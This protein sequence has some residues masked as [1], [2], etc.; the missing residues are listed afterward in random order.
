MTSL[1]IMAAA[2]AGIWCPCAMALSQAEFR[3]QITLQFAPHAVAL[4]A[5]E[6]MRIDVH[7]TDMAS[8]GH[9]NLVFVVFEG[10]GSDLR[11]EFDP[12]EPLT[13]RGSYLAELLVRRG[14]LRHYFHRGHSH[15][16][17]LAAN[18]FRLTFGGILD[19][20]TCEFLR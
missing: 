12:A 7:L 20:L 2:L 9:C 5:I 18:Q 3:D 16:A 6:R 14:L 15:G 11:K 17:P 4:E 13:D 10:Q 8:R 1:R 19:G